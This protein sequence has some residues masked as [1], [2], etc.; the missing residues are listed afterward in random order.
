[1]NKQ[2]GYAGVIVTIV[3]LI[4]VGFIIFAGVNSW[5]N[6]ANRTRE[7]VT[8]EVTGKEVKSDGDSES[9]YLIYT[10]DE[11]FENTDAYY[12]DKFNSSDLYG[13]LEIGKKYSCDSF[14]ERNPRW[15]W[16]RNL[17]TCEEVKA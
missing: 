10:K 9:K 16:Y 4:A 14:G 15:S 1:M 3:V 5:N 7:T 6:W 8:I 11:V 17:I 13:Q 2:S 12:F